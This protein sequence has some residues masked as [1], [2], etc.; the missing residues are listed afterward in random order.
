MSLCFLLRFSHVGVQSPATIMVNICNN[1][2][3]AVHCGQEIVLKFKMQC[4]VHHS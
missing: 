3:N 1:N 2:S 4:S